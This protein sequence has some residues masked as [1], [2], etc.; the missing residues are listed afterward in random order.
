MTSGNSGS[1]EDV[2]IT[3][4]AAPPSTSASAAVIGEAP[5]ER[6]S[7]IVPPTAAD[8][9]DEIDQTDEIDEIDETA[10]AAGF[11]TGGGFA[12]VPPCSGGYAPG[13]GV[14]P[15]AFCSRA[16]ASSSSAGVRARCERGC[17]RGT[18]RAGGGIQTS[19]KMALV[20]NWHASQKGNRGPTH[21]H[22]IEGPLT[23]MQSRAHSRACKAAHPDR[24]ERPPSA[25]QSPRRQ[26][27]R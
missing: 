13:L 25:A 11:V 9:A 18:R 22:A 15:M 19:P 17:E 4:S 12:R 10:P 7:P 23:S 21:E 27:N 16:V 24:L 2:L 6:T 5:I 8:E 26:G 20:P 1:S 3:S 14:A